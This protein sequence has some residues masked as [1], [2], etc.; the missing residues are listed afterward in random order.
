MK[1]SR[2]YPFER[3]RY[4]YG[5]LLTV[6][7]FE[8]EQ[9]YVN[10]KRRFLNRTLHGTGVVAGLQVVMIDDKS[11]SVQSGIA[12]DDLGRE[13]V[14]PSPVT[15]K[16]AMV[17]GFTNNTYAKDVYLCLAYDE[18]GKE[19]VHSVANSAVRSEEVSEYNRILESYRVFV[20]EDAP[21]WSEFG[22]ATLGESVQTIFDNGQVRIIQFVPTYVNP[23]AELTV[24]VLVEHT[25]QT[26]NLSFAYRLAAEGYTV[27]GA[28]DNN[29]V[30]QEPLTDRSSAYELKFAVRAPE[31]VGETWISSVPSSITVQ[32]G[33]EKVVVTEDFGHAVKVVEGSIEDRLW[34]DFHKRTM[35]DALQV[36]GDHAVYLAKVSLVQVGP[37]YMIESVSPVPFSEYVYPPQVSHRIRRITEGTL[38]GRVDGALG[39]VNGSDS[40]GKDKGAADPSGVSTGTAVAGSDGS[41][42]AGDTGRSGENLKA[43]EMPTRSSGVVTVDLVPRVGR[44]TL[45]KLGRG[46]FTSEIDHGLGKGPVAVVL[47]VVET[48]NENG[49]LPTSN[50]VYS[51][52]VEVFRDSQYNSKVLNVSVGSVLFPERGTFVAGIRV[53][54]L[55][56]QTDVQLRWWAWR[57]VDEANGSAGQDTGMASR[58]TAVNGSRA[59]DAVT[60]SEVAASS[61]TGEGP[62]A[63][64]ED[65]DA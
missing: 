31:A 56:D 23:G 58:K 46:Y 39:G 18:R 20:K 12:L 38:R 9:K 60:Q 7:D 6:R 48:N 40:S 33:D 17:E 53:S 32:I 14:V 54:N 28:D 51:G 44:L 15:L 64:K 65:N 1:D 42:S 45:T 50:R 11:I 41:G 63:T 22:L 30:F 34:S 10:D 19:P 37:T 21:N 26:P 52:D 13:I 24:R 4:F 57:T 43:P 36:S 16:L 62:V 3:N 25:L 8:S 35:D 2:Y 5:K 29:I 49:K 27:V 61:S 55:T 47:S 59:A